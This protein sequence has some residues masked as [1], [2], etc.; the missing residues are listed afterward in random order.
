MV[1]ITHVRNVAR[2]NRI[3]RI[4]S[5]SNIL[6]QLSVEVEYRKVRVEFGVG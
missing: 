4:G 3:S 6:A 5:W 1:S 2:G